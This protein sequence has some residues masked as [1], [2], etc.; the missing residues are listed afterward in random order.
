VI[1]PLGGQRIVLYDQITMLARAAAEFPTMLWLLI[2][3]ADASG[4]SSG[5]AC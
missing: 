2:K 1:V 4:G 3:G 5:A